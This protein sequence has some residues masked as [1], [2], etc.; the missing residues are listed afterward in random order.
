MN[1]DAQK[2]M[3]AYLAISDPTIIYVSL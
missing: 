2:V 1:K 3:S